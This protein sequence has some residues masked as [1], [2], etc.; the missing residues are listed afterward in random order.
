MS[1]L[2]R[3]G[4]TSSSSTTAIANA[5][6]GAHIPDIEAVR[7]G[8]PLPGP[9][10]SPSGAGVIDLAQVR[11]HYDVLSKILQEIKGIPPGKLLAE[12]ELCQRVVGSDRNRFRKAVENNLDALKA[13]RVKLKLE[14]GTDGKIFWGNLSDIAAALNMRDL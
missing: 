11:R 13:Y 12:S 2:V 8:N 9:Q 7:A 1:H 4:R 10:T 14:E 6:V 5:L 3:P